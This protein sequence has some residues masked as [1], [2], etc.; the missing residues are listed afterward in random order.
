MNHGRLYQL[1]FILL[2]SFV[3]FCLFESSRIISRKL[4]VDDSMISVNS[5]Y[6]N[7]SAYGPLSFFLLLLF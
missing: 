6:S 1:F 3:T 2:L 5:L 4:T 7:V